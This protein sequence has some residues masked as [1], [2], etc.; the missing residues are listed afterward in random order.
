M[1][2]PVIMYRV[3][4]PEEHRRTAARLYGQAFGSKFRVAVPDERKRLEILATGLQLPHSIAALSDNQ[5]VGLAGFHGPEGSLT[6]GMTWRVLMGVL[7]PIR[8]VVAGVVLFL[9]MRRSRPGE[10]LMDG[11][12]VSPQVRGHGIGT[13]LLEAVC[14]E[15]RSL[16]LE[17]VRL[18]VVDTN[19]RA[20]NLYL[21]TGFVV[22]RSRRFGCLRWLL[23]FGPAD[24]MVRQL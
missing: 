12:A 9:F 1:S 21:R 3:G 24:T 19:P 10:L 14:Q 17:A 4:I 2:A 15:A 8:G 13:G 5:L 6:E 16:G 23:G 7:G 18:D 11:I 22:V 20:R